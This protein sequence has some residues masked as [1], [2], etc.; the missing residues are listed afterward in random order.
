MKKPN[1]VYFFF[2][3]DRLLVMYMGGRN[4]FQQSYYTLTL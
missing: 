3:I 1:L 4:L 2:I